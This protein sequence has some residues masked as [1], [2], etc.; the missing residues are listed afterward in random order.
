MKS[1]NIIK[2]IPNNATPIG[3]WIVTN[4]M[5]RVLV[6]INAP[7]AICIET[8]TAVSVVKRRNFFIFTREK[9]A[10]A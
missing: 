5:S 7:I 10:V 4:L 8:R 2:V 9:T 6:T 3:K 1:K